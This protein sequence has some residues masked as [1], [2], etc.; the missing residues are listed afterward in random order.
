MEIFFDPEEKIMC[1]YNRAHHI[2]RSR[3]NTHLVKCKKNYPDAKLIECDFNVDHKIPEP[4]LQYH[5]E[6]CPDKV[7]IEYT[8][9]Q[10]EGADPDMYPVQNIAIESEETWDDY[11]VPAYN[12]NKYCENA[13]VIRHIDVQSAAKRKDFR[14][15]ERQRLNQVAGPKLSAPSLQADRRPANNGPEMAVRNLPDSDRKVDIVEEQ[16]PELVNHLV[17]RLTQGKAKVYI[18]Q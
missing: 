6:N 9:Y 16:T 10:E 15:K 5:H 3:M 7:K 14:V 1:P 17:K 11:N 8:V 13:E 2:R 4:E 12:P 18:S